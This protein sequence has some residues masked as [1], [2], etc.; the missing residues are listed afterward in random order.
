MREI[1]V[2]VDYIRG[3]RVYSYSKIILGGNGRRRS[4]DV[5]GNPSNIPVLIMRHPEVETFIPAIF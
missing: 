2:V 1:A 4:I 5:S 3:A